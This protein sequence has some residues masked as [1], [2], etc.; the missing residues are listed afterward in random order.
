MGCA[1]S[2]PLTDA[3]TGGV[4]IIN[5]I[6]SAAGAPSVASKQDGTML[7][8]V[9]SGNFGKVLS[10]A[11]GSS[12]GTVVIDGIQMNQGANVGAPSVA[13]KSDGTMLVGVKSG[14]FGKVL[15]FAPGSS[16]VDAGLGLVVIDGIQGE[17]GAPSVAVKSDGTVLVGVKHN[18]VGKVL[19]F[20]PG[21]SEVDAG[22]GLVVIEGI[23]TAE[24]GAPG[25]AVKSDGAVLVAVKDGNVGKIFSVGPAAATV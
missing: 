24:A 2:V 11:P 8:G 16:E 18:N 12:E 19:S 17:A 1:G 14:N 13:V 25:V 21:S 22:L 20:A 10:F 3:V 15:S 5:G 9:K 7:V 23:Q 6:H 4:L